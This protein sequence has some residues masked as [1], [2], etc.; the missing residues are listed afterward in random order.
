MT[1]A[2]S[3]PVWIAD[4]QVERP[5]DSRGEARRRHRACRGPSPRRAPAWSARRHRD[6]ADD[7][8]GVADRLDLLEPVAFG[9]LVEGGEAVDRA[10]RP[11]RAGPR[12][13]ASGVNPTS[14]RTGRSHPRSRR[15]WSSRRPSALGD[16]SRQDVEQQPLRGRVRLG[17]LGGLCLDETSLGE[18]VARAPLEQVGGA[19]TGEDRRADEEDVERGAAARAGRAGRRR[20]PTRYVPAATSAK[21]NRSRMTTNAKIAMSRSAGAAYRSRRAGRLD[22]REDREAG[23]SVQREPD[24][25]WRSSVVAQ[26]ETMTPTQVDRGHPHADDA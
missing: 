21:T 17:Q 23:E 3:G 15:R 13:A 25:C 2:T 4:P 1:P 12:L 20:S 26:R 6:A 14:R 16:G 11:S 24:D 18:D 19:E 10:A 7:H 22:E 8:V 5:A 9:Q